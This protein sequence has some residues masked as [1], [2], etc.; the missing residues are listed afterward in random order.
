METR[1]YHRRAAEC[2]A[3]LA[4]RALGDY[5]GRSNTLTETVE[6]ERRQLL[7]TVKLALT[8]TEAHYYA[9]QTAYTEAYAAEGFAGRAE[10]AY[11]E[12][13]ASAAHFADMVR[14]WKGVSGTTCPAWFEALPFEA[15]AMRATAEGWG[16]KIHGI[17]L[18]VA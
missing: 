11:T 5:L 12:A 9:A 1:S 4:M 7:W 13:I 6:E 2:S 14:P 3:M 16:P 10:T 8:A 15:A 17:R 18:E